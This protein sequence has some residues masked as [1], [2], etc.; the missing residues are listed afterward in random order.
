M[1]KENR[2]S[3]PSDLTDRQWKEID[4]SS[5]G[6]GGFYI[7]FINSDNLESIFYSLLAMPRTLCLDST[8]IKVHPDS[9]G[10]L[11]KNGQTSDWQN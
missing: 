6:A 2:K 3:Y 11:K 10:A 5:G 7:A 9:H 4:I 1:K 8:C